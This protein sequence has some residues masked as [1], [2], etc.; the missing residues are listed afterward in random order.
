MF[1]KD[2]HVQMTSIRWTSIA[3]KGT[4]I[5]WCNLEIIFSH[6]QFS[7]FSLISQKWWVMHFFP[8]INS[9]LLPKLFFKKYNP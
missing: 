8:L 1:M 7:Y 9:T 6:F 3:E 4:R 5:V 2:L